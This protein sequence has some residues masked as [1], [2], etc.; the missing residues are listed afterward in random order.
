MTDTDDKL[1]TFDLSDAAEKLRD[2]IKFG[3]AELIPNDQWEAMIKVEFTKFTKSTPNQYS[4]RPDI[5]STMETLCQVALK[6]MAAEKIKE[7]L[8]SDGWLNEA[9]WDGNS[10]KAV[11]GVQIKAFL[12]ENKDDLI[13][14][15]LK[16]AMGDAMNMLLA[17]VQNRMDPNNPNAF[18]RQY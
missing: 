6:E 17:E 9:E 7:L 3:F 15:M 5:P 18:N 13:A 2:K 4:G 1:A 11:M 12:L 14:S 10:L 8:T 16:T